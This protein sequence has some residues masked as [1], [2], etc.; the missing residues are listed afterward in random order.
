MEVGATSVSEGKFGICLAK[1]KQYIVLPK[2]GHRHNRVSLC[3]IGLHSA[4]RLCQYRRAAENKELVD[5]RA[6]TDLDGGIPRIWHH[7]DVQFI[8]NR[9]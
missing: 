1:L 7:I 2:A 4:H 9:L 8:I 6:L 3:Y 5:A